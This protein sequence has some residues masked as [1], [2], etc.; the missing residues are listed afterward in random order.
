[1]SKSAKAVVASAAGTSASTAYFSQATGKGRM[2]G[3]SRFEVVARFLL[4]VSI[5]T[6]AVLAPRQDDLMVP[7]LLLNL[8]SQVTDGEADVD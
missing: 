5:V 6:G 8:R 3:D 2:L 7:G 1:M 4:P